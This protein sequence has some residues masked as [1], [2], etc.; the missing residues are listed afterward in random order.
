MAAFTR[1][2]ERETVIAEAVNN[3]PFYRHI[4][5]QV[6]AFTD[7]GSVM[8]MT[9]ADSH[10]NIYGTA[11]GGVIASLADSSCGT[12]V[13]QALAMN[14]AAVTFDLRIQFLA[15]VTE[16]RL[17]AYGR[18]LHRTPRHVL[19]ETEIYNESGELKARG[20]SI[21]S[22]VPNTLLSDQPDGVDS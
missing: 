21:H 15:P 8:E 2:T 14:E 11:H 19:A 22:I 16:N 4:K 3:S 7:Q 17:T 18:V 13:I 9:I 12:S 5:M 1:D 10:T 20:S 6:T